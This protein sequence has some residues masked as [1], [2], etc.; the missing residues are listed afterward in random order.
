MDEQQDRIEWKIEQNQ[1]KD[2]EFLQT[3]EFSLFLLYINKNII[4]LPK[5]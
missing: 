2:H 4:F 3:F 1:S 5:D